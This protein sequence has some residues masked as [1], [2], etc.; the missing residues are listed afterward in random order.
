ML[1]LVFSRFSFKNFLKHNSPVMSRKALFSLKFMLYSQLLKKNSTP[2]SDLF[3]TVFLFV[4][5]GATHK[6]SLMSLSFVGHR[7][8]NRL[9][10][11]PIDNK[12]WV[13]DS[14][15]WGRSKR[16]IFGLQVTQEHRWR[17]WMTWVTDP[18]GGNKSTWINFQST[19]NGEISGNERKEYW[20]LYREGYGQIGGC[21]AW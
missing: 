17:V 11:I 5:F 13:L 16:M 14:S 8:M 12:H 4:C 3:L 20:C 9:W 19:M 15:F 21:G 7:T 2:C 6:F 1:L 10:K 18:K